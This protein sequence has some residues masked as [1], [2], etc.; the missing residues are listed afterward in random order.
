MLPVGLI[1]K[2]SR[3]NATIVANSCI[4]CSFACHG[5]FANFYGVDDTEQTNK[6]VTAEPV[7]HDISKSK[8]GNQSQLELAHTL[9]VR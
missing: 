4:R 1:A 7:Q 9:A 5:W 6:K 8:A 2:L 3:F